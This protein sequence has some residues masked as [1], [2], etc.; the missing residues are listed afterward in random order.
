[1]VDTI[2]LKLLA[3]FMLLSLPL[4]GCKKDTHKQ[5]I[6]NFDYG[7]S[8]NKKAIQEVIDDYNK[9]KWF[10]ELYDATKD[11]EWADSSARQIIIMSLKYNSK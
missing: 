6:V 5:Q 9:L 8:D 7:D 2:K 3:A 1:M 4:V 10:N 11:K